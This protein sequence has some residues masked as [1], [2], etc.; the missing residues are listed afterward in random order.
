MC[1]LIYVSYRSMQVYIVYV[2]IRTTYKCLKFLSAIT[3]LYVSESNINGRQILDD[4]TYM[5]QVAIGKIRITAVWKIQLLLII[6]VPF[7][8]RDFTLKQKSVMARQTQEIFS[9][10]EIWRPPYTQLHTTQRIVCR[11]SCCIDRKSWKP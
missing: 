2:L 8:T 9:E 1:S 3:R 5:H 7:P 6:T 10:H 11:R 4:N